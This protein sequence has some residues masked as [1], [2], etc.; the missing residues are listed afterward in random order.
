MSIAVVSVVASALITL[1]SLAFS[2]FQARGQRRHDATQAFEERAW[3]L[4]VEAHLRLI[5]V[6]ASM[7][8][9]VDEPH[10]VALN[11][12][13][14]EEELKLEIQPSVLAYGSDACQTDLE[15]LITLTRKYA[16]HVDLF[17]EVKLR[18]IRQAKERAIDV[19]DF[20]EA[21]AQRDKERQLIDRVG[22]GFKYDP[23]ELRQALESAIRSTRQSLRGER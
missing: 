1:A 8:D 6:S 20:E 22:N 3:E 19:H 21:A 23:A 9:V 16:D 7:L 17:D 4:K 15:A 11:A 13:R 12:S 2:F 10:Q 18:N 14:T 5:Q